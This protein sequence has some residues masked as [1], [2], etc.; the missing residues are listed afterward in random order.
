MG[1]GNVATHPR[2][3]GFGYMKACMQASLDEMI[4]KDID[5]GFLGGRR[6]R[7]R[8]FGYEKCSS[9]MNFSVSAKIM[10]YF[11]K[12]LEQTVTMI[13]VRESDDKILD[14]IFEAHR[15]RPYHAE[16]PRE[17]IFEIMSSW[18]SKILAFYKE[19]TLVGW[20]VSQKK[21]YVSEIVILDDTCT[22]NMLYQIVKRNGTQKF[23]VPSFEKYALRALSKYTEN[24][25]AGSNAC[26]MVLNYQRVLDAALAL[27]ASCTPLPDCELTVKINGIKKTEILRISVKDQKTS[28]CAVDGPFDYE[29]SHAEAQEFLFLGYT[30]LR[31]GIP[32]AHSALLPLPLFM[33]HVDNV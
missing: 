9:D 3:R 8:N 14:D 30:P 18:Y 23:V 20:A 26:F 4:E 17:R 13:E 1:I 31:D 12:D 6:H 16:R 29:L 2:F 21:D 28:V 33:P 15:S 11:P 5:F 10:S 24:V 22:G 7:Y 25:F 32:F 27:K 19:D